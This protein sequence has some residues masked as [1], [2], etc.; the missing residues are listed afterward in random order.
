MWRAIR[1]LALV[2]VGAVVFSKMSTETRERLTHI[3]SSLSKY[4]DRLA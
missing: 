2:A 1:V 4:I 3:G